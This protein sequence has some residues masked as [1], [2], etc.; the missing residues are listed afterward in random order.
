[1]D[2]QRN[3]EINDPFRPVFCSGIPRLAD[4]C[5][6]SKKRALCPALVDRQLR[7]AG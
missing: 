3:D 4:F 6:K 2:N 7:Q 1:M 5:K